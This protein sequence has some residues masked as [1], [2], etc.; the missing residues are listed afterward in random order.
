MKLK[1]SK[2]EKNLYK[3]FSGESRARGKYNLYAEKAREEGFRW[4]AEI[5]DETAGNEYAHSREVFEKYLSKIGSTEDNLIDAAYFE[6]EEDKNI[7]KEFEKIA[8]EEG[9]EEIAEF[10]RELREV[11]EKHKER[12]L[13]LCERIRT[14]KMFKSDEI[15]YWQCMNCGYIHEGTEAPAVCPLCKYERAYFKPYCKVNK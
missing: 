1:G 8:E 10:Y 3:T 15:T 6:N 4:V 2:T 7:Y 13:A 5:F 14:G 11:E 12:F 9:F